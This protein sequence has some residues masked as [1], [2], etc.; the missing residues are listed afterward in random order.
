MSA[1]VL[2]YARRAI[3]SIVN[4]HLGGFVHTHICVYRIVGVGGSFVDKMAR[5]SVF[6]QV[7]HDSAS[8]KML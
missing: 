1:I 5:L 2:K 3:I 8:R 4:V 7:I 6:G